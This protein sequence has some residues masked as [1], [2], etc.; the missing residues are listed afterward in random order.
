MKKIKEAYFNKLTFKSKINGLI[1]EINSGMSSLKFKVSPLVYKIQHKNTNET[2]Y[3]MKTISDV[4]PSLVIRFNTDV[5]IEDSIHSVSCWKNYLPINRKNPTPEF[6]IDGFT[7]D[8]IQKEDSILIAEI[9]SWLR[10]KSKQ[11]LYTNM[12][13]VISVDSM[14]MSDI[15]I[16]KEINDIFNISK[17]SLVL[18]N[19]LSDNINDL[20]ESNDSIVFVMT[21]VEESSSIL[22]TLKNEFDI[23]SGFNYF[24][25]NILTDELA[26]ALFINSRKGNDTIILDNFKQWNDSDLMNMIDA[27]I[28][29]GELTYTFQDPE[30]IPSDYPEDGYIDFTVKL[31][32]ITS[33]T[34]ET[35][36]SKDYTF[37][38]ANSSFEEY[39]I[40]DTDKEIEAKMNEILPSFLPKITN[41]FKKDTINYILDN[42][43]K[44]IINV[45]IP[46][47]VI[48]F[49]T[50]LVCKSVWQD[51][52]STIFENLPIES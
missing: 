5:E 26:V 43:D 21:D 42:M 3:G 41:S 48:L 24:T 45:T 37:L 49:E 16:Q 51:Y 6:V 44:K 38:R 25:K 1:S 23:I 27:I 10:S 22:S 11:S 31:I 30:L 9:I 13:S 28:T 39:D 32:I 40:T 52:F 7:E 46:E 8:Q 34:E 15:R 29:K 33:E 35:V 14:P 36:S 47:M 19:N 20:R 2:L 50:K 4:N 12:E 17:E 18:E